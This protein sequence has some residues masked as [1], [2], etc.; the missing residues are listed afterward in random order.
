MSKP[1]H[2]SLA[3]KRQAAPDKTYKQL[4]QKQKLRIA[5]M[6]YHVTLRFYDSVK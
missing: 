2:N 1:N 3:Y 6:M 4:K 5:E